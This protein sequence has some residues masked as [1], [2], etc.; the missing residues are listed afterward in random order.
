ML[1]HKSCYECLSVSLSFELHFSQRITLLCLSCDGQTPSCCIIAVDV[2]WLPWDGSTCLCINDSV[3]ESDMVFFPHQIMQDQRDK[4]RRITFPLSFHWKLDLCSLI[5][6]LSLWWPP[7]ILKESDH[8][9]SRRRWQSWSLVSLDCRCR[10][11]ESLVSWL[12]FCFCSFIVFSR[13][14]FFR[15]RHLSVNNEFV[16]W[17]PSLNP[18]LHVEKRAGNED[19]D[20]DTVNSAFCRKEAVSLWWHLSFLSWSH[21]TCFLNRFHFSCQREDL[22]S[23]YPDVFLVASKSNNNWSSSSLQLQNRDDLLFRFFLFS[24]WFFS[25]FSAA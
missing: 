11:L 20:E 9:D 19:E 17:C 5:L 3:W 7:S 21:I 6:S 1:P 4:S 8:F 14:S 15:R 25:A 12:F 10:F 2:I 22:G 23:L 16:L 13:L 18:N 24:L